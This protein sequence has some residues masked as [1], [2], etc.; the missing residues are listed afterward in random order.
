MRKFF[1]CLLLLASTASCFA[2]PK[3][4]ERLPDESIRRNVPALIAL[5]DSPDAL[6]RV[7]AL[8]ALG[9]LKG[10]ATPAISAIAARLGDRGGPVF[11]YMGSGN[12]TRVGE[13]ASYTMLSI[14][15]PAIPALLDA[16]Q[17]GSEETRVNASLALRALSPLNIDEGVPGLKL[18]FW[19]IIL[20][21]LQ[22]KNETVSH[23]AASIMLDWHRRRSWVSN[24]L[25]P[26]I[27]RRTMIISLAL[28]VE[29]FL[30]V[31]YDK[32]PFVRQTILQFLPALADGRGRDRIFEALGDKEV[33][34]RREAAALIAELGGNWLY[35][36]RA[37]E[38][39]LLALSSDFAEG[40]YVSNAAHSLREYDNPRVNDALL[41]VLKTNN[42][43]NEQTATI[44]SLSA[45]KEMR[46][47]EPLIA[48]L[49]AHPPGYLNDLR[50]L[51]LAELG[52]KRAIPA[53]AKYMASGFRSY[54]MFDAFEKLAGQSY[55][56]YQAEHEQKQAG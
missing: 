4:G 3:Q 10:N 18:E 48:A 29:P 19:P 43:N 23:S 24:S 42:G 21:A 56:Q 38:P 25:S 45:R 14:G 17:T 20:A 7:Q 35:D 12:P 28:P 9:E 32:R 13:R 47:V 52:D 49:Q 33:S 8:N 34:V 11:D 22:D 15:V 26:P 51:T 46:A 37:L 16:L 5:L 40:N 54:Q 1:L 27:L 53:I 2:K 44:E 31:S 50:A 39:L 55:P 41:V 30:K 6:D 36:P